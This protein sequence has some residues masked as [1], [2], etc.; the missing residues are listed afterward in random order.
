MNFIPELTFQNGINWIIKRIFVFRGNE[1]PFIYEDINGY[2]HLLFHNEIPNP[3]HDQYFAG[4]H[5]ASYDGY[6]WVYFGYAYDTNISFIQNENENRMQNFV[7]HS[8]ERPHLVFDKDG[9]TPLAL[10]NGVLVNNNKYGDDRS[11]T[12]L[13]PINQDWYCLSWFVYDKC[14]KSFSWK[15][16]SP[17]TCGH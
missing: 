9:V 1:D 6:N 11:I 13:Q 15:I 12:F 14:S 7:L 10:T 2:Y 16:F 5:A 17:Y 8:R 4:G 3:D